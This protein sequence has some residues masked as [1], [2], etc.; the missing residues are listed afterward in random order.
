[1]SKTQKKSS[2]VDWSAG[3][4]YNSQRELL[5]ISEYGRS[6][7]NMVTYAV[8]IEDRD[9]RNKAAQAIVTAMA[10]L[11][12]QV[13]ELV[14]YKHKLWDHLFILSDFKLDVD[15]PFPIP[16]KEVVKA[17]P[18]QLHYPTS[19]IRYKYY[20]KV[21]EAMIRKIAE[22]EE[23]PRKEQI[24]QNLANFMKM[25]YL[26][27]NKDTVDD[28]TILKHLEELS[29]GNLRLHE[30]AKLNH[31]AEILAMNKEKMQRENALK[32]KNKRMIKGKGKR[33]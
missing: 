30:S 3:M 4:D 18:R 29:A 9:A 26:T 15:S 14:D 27:W 11:N 10:C 6:I 21:M 20:G 19:D 28:S 1:M 31:T 17:K 13:R 25:S 33:K 16:S 23:G 8:T 5:P 32:N 7:R 2:F 22:M 24:T 12:P